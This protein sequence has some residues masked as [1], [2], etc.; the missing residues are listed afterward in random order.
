MRPTI[1]P[2]TQLVAC[3]LLRSLRQAASETLS[4]SLVRGR[5]EAEEQPGASS[6]VSSIM[7]QL[8]ADTFSGPAGDLDAWTCG[9]TDELAVIQQEQ[10]P[11]FR[12]KRVRCD[13]CVFEQG[14]REWVLHKRLFSVAAAALSLGR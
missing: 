11:S 14:V 4:S 8:P 7:A 3:F 5:G 6:A 1:R 10:L 13:C 9:Y 12:P 2:P